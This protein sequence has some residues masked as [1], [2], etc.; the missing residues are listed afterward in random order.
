MR[1]VFRKQ[2][3]AA[4]GSAISPA[5]ASQTIVGTTGRMDTAGVACDLWLVLLGPHHFS[6]GLLSLLS[7]KRYTAC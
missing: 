7:L 5:G 1:L 6:Q 4:T 2:P 3:Y